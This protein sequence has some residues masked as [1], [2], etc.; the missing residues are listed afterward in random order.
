MPTPVRPITR[1]RGAASISPAPKRWPPR[2]ITASAS[3][4]SSRRCASSR[5][6][7][8]GPRSSSVGGQTGPVATTLV[9]EALEGVAVALVLGAELLDDRVVGRL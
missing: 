9:M 4:S 6:T 2:M 1:S 7:A 8:T 5:A 3:R